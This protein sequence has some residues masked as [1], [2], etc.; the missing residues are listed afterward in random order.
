MNEAFAS[1]EHETCITENEGIERS[2][3]PARIKQ[4]NPVTVDYGI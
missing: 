4:K 2:L 3:Y 1:A